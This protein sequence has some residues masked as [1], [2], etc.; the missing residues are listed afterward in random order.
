[1]SDDPGKAIGGGLPSN[2]QPRAHVR[3]LPPAMAE[4][5]WKPGQSGNPTGKTGEYHRCRALCRQ[6]SAAA[7][8]EII[9]L[10]K[11]SSDDRV[12]YMS[13]QW[14]YEQAWGKAQPYDPAT[15]PEASP[16]LDVTVLTPEQRHELRL[17]ID[18]MRAG[19]RVT[20]AETLSAQDGQER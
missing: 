3:V 9:R 2:L 13:A 17:L 8:E 19:K 18:L 16:P 20:E 1:M 7:A 4:R 10:Y 15:D 6:A 11:E 14:V 5:M 12:R